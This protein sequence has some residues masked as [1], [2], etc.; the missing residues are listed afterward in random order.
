MSRPCRSCARRRR[1][2][3]AGPDDL[4]RLPHD[5]PVPRRLVEQ[6]LSLARDL[7][8]DDASVGTMIHGDL[9]Y[10]NVLAGDRSR[11]W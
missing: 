6:A 3:R 8:A 4:E 1:T 2:S 5:A 10:E 9:H 7:A 11:G